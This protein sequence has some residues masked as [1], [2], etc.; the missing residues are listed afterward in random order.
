[1]E[2]KNGAIFEE[3]DTCGGGGGGR[4]KDGNRRDTN[5]EKP[6]DVEL[7][8]LCFSSAILLCRT[9]LLP[10]PIRSKGMRKERLHPVQS[11]TLRFTFASIG[12]C[13]LSSDL[14]RPC[15]KCREVRDD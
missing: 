5:G 3:E 9:L 2:G 14:E 8:L 7:P 12:K 15:C 11:E 10:T 4:C 6:D 13:S 1:M